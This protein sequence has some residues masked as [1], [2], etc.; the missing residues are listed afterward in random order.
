VKFRRGLLLV[1]ALA[2]L[3]ATVALLR[4]AAPE[5]AYLLVVQTSSGPSW[6]WTRSDPTAESEGNT[7]VTLDAMRAAA[8]GAATTIEL[9]V[10]PT[11]GADAIADLCIAQDLD[12]LVF[13]S[14]ALMN[15]SVHRKRLTV[16]VLWAEG[17][18]ESETITSMACVALDVRS[19]TTIAAFLRDH[20]DHSTHVAMLSP[21]ALAVDIEPTFLAVSGI[22]AEVEV[23]SPGEG[24]SIN[25]WLALAIRD[26]PVDLLVF[27]GS[28]SAAL[29]DVRRGPVLLV[30][31]LPTATR[32]FRRRPIDVP[33]LLDEAGRIR[34]R[35]DQGAAMGSLGPLAGQPVA[36]VARGKV[37]ASAVTT[38]AGEAEIAAGPDIVSLGVYCVGNGDPPD[39]LAAIEQ[40]VTVI[41]PGPEPVVVF[42]AELSDEALRTLLEGTEPN[43]PIAAM[44]VRMRPNRSCRAIRERLRNLGMPAIVLDARA[45]LDEGQAL[46]V[47]D[48]FDAVRLARVVARLRRAGFQIHGVQAD[49][50]DDAIAGNRI[51]MELHNPT[52]RGWLLD[53]IANSTSSFHLQVYAAYDDD[54]GRP[55]GDQLAAAAAR[56]VTVRLLVDSLHGLHGS[57]GTRNPL[58]ERLSERP[59][60]ELRVV[61]PI[62]ETP[63]LTALKQ[64]DHRKLAIADGRV[65]LVGGRNLASEYYTGFEEAQ[66]RPES[67]WRE[68]PW[69]DCGARIEGPAVGTLQEA[70]LEAW[71][72]AG[73]A[74]FDVVA[75]PAVGSSTVRVVVHRGLRDAHALETYLDLIDGAKSHVYLVNGFPLALELQHALL[76]ALRRGVRVRTLFGRLTPTHGGEPFGGPWSAARTMATELVHSRMDPIVAAG[77]DCYLF[78]QS[79][80]PS[81]TPGLGDINPHVHAK[82]LSVDGLRCTVGSANMDITAAYWESE[83]LLVVEDASVTAEFEA[84]V[85]VLMAGSL[86][87]DRNDPVWQQ[88]SKR[89][90]WM[91]HWP[92]V[93]SV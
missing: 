29:L 30:P 61:R 93:L 26:R 54:V 47:S 19:L 81:W 83:L 27:V 82:A 77:G 91:R 90:A 65:A 6:W 78:V 38:A 32:S 42:D 84:E 13:G 68:V 12:L 88:L 14:R 66:L 76:R 80:S 63:S 56:G 49:V 45:V 79:E 46:D 71:V 52:A 72:E 67:S 85:D 36:F 40:I 9:Q 31:P 18:W 57:F 25:E 28:T 23:A 10:A 11:L 74:P 92:G 62:L 87:L 51:E 35:I 70:F 1:D 75:P 4:R 22:D 2:D 16:A 33:D 5:L 17:D 86:L 7:R 20:G 44:A 89:R 8:A 59:G 37:V 48:S 50:V 55:V 39:P 73:G 58:L 69:L 21:S 24:D 3:D 15:A 64:R 53:A 34:V 43:A 41:R 60:V